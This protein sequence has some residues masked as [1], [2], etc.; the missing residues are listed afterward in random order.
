MINK[1][2]IKDITEGK[3]NLAA[4]FGIHIAPEETDLYRIHFLLPGPE[5]TPYYGGLYH[6][7]IR[8]NQN[9]PINPPNIHMI[10]PS[11]RF[12]AEAY[13]ISSTSR[14][15]CTTTSAF[16][17]DEWTPCNNIETVLKGFVSLM[18]DPND[19]GVGGLKSTDN[20]KKLFAKNS[21]PSLINNPYIKTLFPDIY[22]QLIDNTYKPFAEIKKK[23]TIV[24][25]NKPEQKNKLEQKNIIKLKKN[26]SNKKSSKQESSDFDNSE[27]SDSDIDNSENSNS[28]IDNSDIDN[29]DIDNS[30]VDNSD[31]DNSDVDNSDVDNSDVDN[32]EN[33]TVSDIDSSISDSSEKSPIYKPKNKK[34]TKKVEP[35][36]KPKKL[37]PIKKSKKV[38]PIKKPKKIV[39][40][41]NEDITLKKKVKSNKKK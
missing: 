6:G 18:C 20:E 30:D 38:E 1:R 39:S 21:I 41:K 31:V 17:P 28:D 22:Q 13:P 10:T 40:K 23:Y 19:V 14:G 37:V 15:I 34:H 8:L 2:V 12:I 11:G 33:S 9:H 36:Q 3:K 29:S 35:I 24:E 7:M 5:N 4:E 16:H 25:K 27:N 26:I 32:S